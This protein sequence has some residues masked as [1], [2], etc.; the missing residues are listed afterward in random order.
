MQ[1]S[2][3]FPPARHDLTSPVRALFSPFRRGMES[4]VWHTRGDV[5]R[6]LWARVAT[7]LAIPDRNRERPLGSLAALGLC[8]SLHLKL[9]D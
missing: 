7:T 8:R 9:G 2:L 6:F 1:G 3:S 5:C 4:T